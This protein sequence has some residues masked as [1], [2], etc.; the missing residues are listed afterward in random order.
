[1]VCYS[2]R[3]RWPILYLKKQSKPILSLKN[4]TV[5]IDKRPTVLSE[6]KF[7]SSW[8]IPAGDSYMAHLFEDAGADYMFKDL[9]GAGS[10]P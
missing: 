2:E 3:K 6:K 8:Y 5:N 1:M 10:T 9:P 7:G 4:L